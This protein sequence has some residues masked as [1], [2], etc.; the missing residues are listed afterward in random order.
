MFTKPN[1]D[2]GYKMFTKVYVLLVIYSD[3]KNKKTEKG[4]N[5]AVYSF[6]IG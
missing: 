3:R 4:K 6:L 5:F 2:L 1:T